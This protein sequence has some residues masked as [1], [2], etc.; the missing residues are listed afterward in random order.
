MQG[1]KYGIYHHHCS[2]MVTSKTESK[3]AFPPFL[4]PT[5][6]SILRLVDLA[7]RI[8][9]T[10]FQKTPAQIQKPQWGTCAFQPEPWGMHRSLAPGKHSQPRKEE[11]SAR[12]PMCHQGK[13]SDT[14]NPQLRGVGTDSIDKSQHPASETAEHLPLS[15]IS[16]IFLTKLFSPRFPGARPINQ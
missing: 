8:K 3:P 4:P 2:S 13:P 9:E 5:E 12:A 14:R 16:V 6:R 10:E 15:F 1:A 7:D 11:S